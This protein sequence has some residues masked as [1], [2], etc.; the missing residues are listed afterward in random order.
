LFDENDTGNR[1]KHK[2]SEHPGTASVFTGGKL[3]E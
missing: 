3:E 2:P 1:G